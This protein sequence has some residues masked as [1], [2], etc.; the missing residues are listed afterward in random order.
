MWIKVFYWMR[1]FDFT[2]HYVKL[3]LRIIGD[4][5]VF[6]TML[7]IILLAYSNFFYIINFNSSFNQENTE[8]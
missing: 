2:A 5:K 7:L 1:L 6:V 4:V 8:F 3:I